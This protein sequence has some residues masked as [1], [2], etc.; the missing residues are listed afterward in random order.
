MHKCDFA[1]CLEWYQTVTKT[2]MDARGSV[3]V[4]VARDVYQSS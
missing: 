2:K 4:T 1:L 3:T